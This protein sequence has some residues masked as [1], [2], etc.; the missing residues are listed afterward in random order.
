MKVDQ[1][2]QPLISIDV[3]PVRFNTGAATLEVGTGRRVFEP[4]V[5]EQ[6][7]PGV[8]LMQGET[9]QHAAFRAL[10]SKAG[11][12]A[13]H[14][15][16]LTQ[17]GAFDGTNRDPRGATISIALLSVQEFG[18]TPSTRVT[19]TPAA[20]AAG[21]P[22]DH[23]NIVKAALARLS[24]LLWVDVPATK[25]LL[26]SK[27]STSDALALSEALGAWPT[28]ASN[29]GRWLASNKAVEKLEAPAGASGRGRPSA[30]W[31]WA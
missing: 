2:E 27:F 24:Q 29:F 7:L 30:M 26:G 15:G 12:L 16:Y 1:N 3:V 11:I 20:E 21:L 8:L 25:A 6:A 5:G 28:H 14:S 17:F 13:E 19:W 18:R 4:F 23:D 22:F 9:I 10:N 31:R